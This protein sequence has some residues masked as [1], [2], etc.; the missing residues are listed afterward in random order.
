MIW[1]ILSA[2]AS[3]FVLVVGYF[4]FVPADSN[5]LMS[6]QSVAAQLPIVSAADLAGL[7][8]I[9]SMAFTGFV[10]GIVIALIA[11]VL[12][13]FAASQSDEQDSG[14]LQ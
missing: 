12:Y 7:S 13:L 6:L 5:V 1:K 9:S 4:V 14:L 3:V 10:V 8:Q 11:V 2:T